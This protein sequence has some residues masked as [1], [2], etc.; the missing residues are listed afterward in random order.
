MKSQRGMKVWLHRF[1]TSAF[2]W[3]WVASADLRAGRKV[4]LQE[5][6]SFPVLICKLWR[7]EGFIAPSGIRIAAPCV[8]QPVA[9]S[10]YRTSYPGSRR[11][12][13]FNVYHKH[14]ATILNS[15]L[16]CGITWRENKAYQ[17][18]LAKRCGMNTDGYLHVQFR[19]KLHC[20]CEPVASQ[21][22][23]QYY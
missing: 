19:N 8:V 5:G 15:G 9:W 6:K 21:L 11:I 3:V 10:L 1:L 7:R 17:P 4:T 12:R 2:G 23:E 14:S 16:F 18:F 20:L 22:Q 13:L